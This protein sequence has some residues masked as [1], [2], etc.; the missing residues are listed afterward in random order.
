MAAAARVMEMEPNVISSITHLQ[1]LDGDGID[2][3]NAMDDAQNYVAAMR[4]E[5]MRRVAHVKR[6][7][8]DGTRAGMCQMLHPDCRLTQVSSP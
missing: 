2:M 3:S 8:S 5:A 4:K 1:S 7:Y 6:F